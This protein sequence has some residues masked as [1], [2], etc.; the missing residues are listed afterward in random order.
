MSMKPVVEAQIY[1]KLPFDCAFAPLRED[2]ISSS[3]QNTIPAAIYP[4]GGRD[5]PGGTLVL[6]TEGAQAP[7]V[8]VMMQ[9]V[10]ADR[11][12]FGIDHSAE[13]TATAEAARISAPD[14]RLPT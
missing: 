12:I 14:E 1:K 13:G 8:V 11:Q 6:T 3:A 5:A 7:G 2:T 4:S 9:R 10:T